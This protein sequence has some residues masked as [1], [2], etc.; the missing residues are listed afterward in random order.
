MLTIEHYNLDIKEIQQIEIW[1]NKQI[2]ELIFDT[3]KD[4]QNGKESVFVDKVFNKPNLIF[5]IED[6]E[7]NK[8]GGYSHVACSVFNRTSNDKNSFYSH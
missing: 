6:T 5:V 4:N 2:G 3:K 1:S 7:G 8:F